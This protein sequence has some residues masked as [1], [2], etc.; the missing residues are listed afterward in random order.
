M[1]D[2][3]YPS[4]DTRQEGMPLIL[5]KIQGHW[6]IFPILQKIQSYLD[7]HAI[8]QRTQGWWDMLPILHRTRDNNGSD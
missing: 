1:R 2:A 8:L 5:Q 3:S 4:K 6:E 7:R